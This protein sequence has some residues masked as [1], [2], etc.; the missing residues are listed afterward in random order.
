MADALGIDEAQMYVGLDYR[1]TDKISIHPPSVLSIIK[2]GEQEYFSAVHA[3]TCIPSDMKYHLFT[4]GIDYEE[5]SDY[6]LFLGLANSLQQHSTSL[7]FGDLD[8]SAM[9]RYK[10]LETGDECLCNIEKEI[11]IDKL[12]YAKIST[13]LRKMHDIHP[14]VEHAATKTVKR[15]LIEEDEKRVKKALSEDYKSTLRPLLSAMMRYPGFKYKS[16]ELDR[17]SIY[18]FMDTVKG[19]QIYVSTNALIH[20]SYS[21]M[22][23]TSKIPKKD[24][25]WMRDAD[26]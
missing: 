1:V 2:F 25:N 19:S 16:D 3:L 14:K 23:D 12:V 10:D 11:K 15:I 6:H 20:G 8:F 9:Q 26:D 7:L 22:I 17:C 18:E 5:I 21:G 13:Y 4:Q 24:F